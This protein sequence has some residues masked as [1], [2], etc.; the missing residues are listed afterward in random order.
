MAAAKP[1]VLKQHADEDWKRN[2]DRF[3]S[4]QA[5]Y[6]TISIFED[7]TAIEKLHGRFSKFPLTVFEGFAEHSNAMHQI[8]IWTALELEGLGA[9]LQHSHFVPGVEDGIRSA[10]S[11]PSTWS[12]KAE[13]VFGGLPGEMPTVP[14]KE[15]VSTTV[16]VY[17]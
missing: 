10:F 11:I 7:H 5:A 14:E 17:R 15:P 16:K 12:I 6:G 1:L 8:T 4:F 9:R 3:Q 13:I 2:D